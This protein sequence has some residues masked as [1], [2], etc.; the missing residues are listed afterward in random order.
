MFEHH[1]RTLY[2]LLE[3]EFRV[4]AYFLILRI[5]RPGPNDSL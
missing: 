4:L 2:V 1:Q 3:R 5:R